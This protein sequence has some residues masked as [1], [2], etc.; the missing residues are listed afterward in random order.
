MDK[1]KKAL[2]EYREVFDDNFPTIP[3]SGRTE[4]ELLGIIKDCL[5]KG[6][7]VYDCGYLDLN[8]IY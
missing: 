1:L 8:R 3:F 7:D 6:K 4:E 5:E 2:S